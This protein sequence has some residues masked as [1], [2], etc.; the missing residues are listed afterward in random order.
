MNESTTFNYNFASNNCRHFCV[1]FI[2]NELRA[3]EFDY[4]DEALT[5]LEETQMKDAAVGVG[6]GIG[7]GLLGY[8]LYQWMNSGKEVDNQPKTLNNSESDSESDS[9]SDVKRK[10]YYR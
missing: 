3:L 10:Y 6:I 2:K 9:D 8:G 5:F 7:L 1:K 4:L